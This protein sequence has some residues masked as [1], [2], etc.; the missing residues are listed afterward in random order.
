MIGTD[1]ANSIDNQN[2]S[3]ANGKSFFGS[4]RIAMVLVVVL[5]AAVIGGAWLWMRRGRETTDDAHVD[6]RV[7]EISARVGGTVTRV[8]VADNQAVDSGTVLVE[9]DTRD[10]QVALDRARAELANAEASAVAANANVPITSTAATSNVTNAQGSVEQAQNMILGA[11]KEVEAAQARLAAARARQR[12]VEANAARSARDVDRLR[13]LLA[14]DEVSRAQ[15]DAASAAAEAQKA[16]VESAHAQVMEA[17]AG[18]HVVGSRLQQVR[19]GEQQARASLRSAETAPEQVAATRAQ[20]AAAAARVDVARAM[21]AQAELNLQHAVVKAPAKGVVAKKGVNV[22]EVVQP[23]QPLFALVEVDNI[24]VTANFKETQLA[25]MKPGQSA[26]ID[27]DAYGGR[28]FEGRVDSIS[29]ATGARFSLLPPENATGN[30]VKVVQRV[31]VKIVL[32]SGQDPEHLLR[33]GMSVVPTVNT[34]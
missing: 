4:R 13:G 24:W 31:P 14:K 9:L 33:P 32:D 11:Q 10:F 25:N 26:T 15:F 20:A 6:G 22:G 17:E 27:V 34:R 12:E 2:T 28:R 8:A 7:T 21:V 18:I 5:L 16:A 3:E 29:P 30:F 1:V 19:A 23:G